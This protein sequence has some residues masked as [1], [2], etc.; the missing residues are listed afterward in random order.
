LILCETSAGVGLYKLSDKKMSK[1]NN[2]DDLLSHF[3]SNSLPVSLHA[4]M[5]F[6]DSA[7]AMAIASSLI[8]GTLEKP[9]LKFLKKNMIDGEEL[10]VAEKNLAGAVS[11]ALGVTVMSNQQTAVQLWRGV[12]E[13]LSTVHVDMN[14]TDFSQM[15]CSL[16]H[17]MNSFKLKFSPDK[18]DTMIIQ[19][20][21]LLDDLDKELNNLAMRLK[22]WYGWHFPELVKIVG[23]AGTYAR[24]VLAIGMRDRAKKME[25]IEGVDS[26]LLVDVKK[27]AEI[28]MGTEITEEDLVHIQELA[29]RVIELTNYR[30]SLADY[31]S[32]R[33]QAISPNL[34]FMVGELV[35]ARLIS[36]AGSLMNLAKHPSST[37][38][39]LGAE[40]ALFRALKTKQ[41]TPKY[42]L[43]Y[44]ASVVG[45]SQPQYKGKI[46]R[47]LAA[48]LSLCA[49]VDALGDQTEVSVARVHKEYVENRLEQFEKGEVMSFSKQGN[50]Q[51]HKNANAGG[52][53]NKNAD[54]KRR[55]EGGNADAA[56]K[57]PRY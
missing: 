15:A 17:Q 21:G 9:I 11:K 12:R 8:E 39:I 2:S 18:V 7:H 41:S 36:H 34:T 38:Q 57:R 55:F 50:S 26:E 37:V 10:V 45:Q 20:V 49:R 44:H 23:D 48:K 46:S 33:M 30:I 13:Q 22:E 5:P 14:E 32:Q 16:S 25:D 1:L 47:V 24:V 31:L 4:Y 28:S 53:Y 54:G 35:G 56:P 6:K 29:E 51:F 43:I 42:G 27:A 40:K 19:A 52:A 3:Q